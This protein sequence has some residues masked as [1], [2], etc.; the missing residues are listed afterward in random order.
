MTEE[1]K[2]IKEEKHLRAI[3]FFNNGYTII[4]TA[5]GLLGAGF[6]AGQFQKSEK[7]ER[8][9]TQKER[10]IDQKETS[11]KVYMTQYRNCMDLNAKLNENLTTLKNES[12]TEFQQTKVNKNEPVGIENAK[13]NNAVVNSQRVKSKDNIGRFI[14]PTFPEGFIKLISFDKANDA[15]YGESFITNGVS[16][17]EIENLT[18]QITITKTALLYKTA[19]TS[20]NQDFNFNPKDVEIIESNQLF[21]IAGP[22]FKIEEGNLIQYWCKVKK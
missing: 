19:P 15:W 18:G 5:I 17:K 9:M 1:E 16:Q 22:V 7:Y 11:M 6:I 4:Y 13:A 21:F 20:F 3:T 14:P 10:I 2:H 8:E 12:I